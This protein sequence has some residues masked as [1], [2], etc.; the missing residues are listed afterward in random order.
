[1]EESLGGPITQGKKAA[2]HHLCLVKAGVEVYTGG[3][4]TAEGQHTKLRECYDRWARSIMTEDN[5]LG[6]L[7]VPSYVTEKMFL[8]SDA[9]NRKLRA[10]NK[11]ENKKLWRQWIL[12]KSAITNFD[13][14]AVKKA[15][16]R[17]PGK[18]LPSGSDFSLFLERLK[19]ELH[20][21]RSLSARNKAMVIGG[22]A[23]KEADSPNLM[24]DPATENEDAVLGDGTNEEV[25]AGGLGAYTR[26][27]SDDEEDEEM[28]E[29]LAVRGEDD[30]DNVEDDSDEPRAP[31]DYCP[32][33]LLVIMTIGVLST[34]TEAVLGYVDDDPD[35]EGTAL[36]PS[37]I[38]VRND[39]VL[40]A[41]AGVLVSTSASTPVRSAVGRLADRAKYTDAYKE[42]MAQQVE[43]GTRELVLQEKGFSLQEREASAKEREAS[44]KEKEVATRDREVT[45]NS[46]RSIYDDLRRDLRD[47]KDDDEDIEE[48]QRIKDEMKSVKKRR[49]DN[50]YQ[51]DI[52]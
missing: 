24:L 35:G 3:K 27:T 5:T 31:K 21:V 28:E 1:M 26:S 11:E 32:P 12:A 17:M 42:A 22:S 6:V 52:T 16:S 33:R 14:I 20:C 51:V 2:W 49:L 10:H 45:E 15:I 8:T 4:L 40:E 50:S 41:A 48:I 39:A 19:Y 9:N 47:A 18:A 36:V 23:A 44:A 7:S 30:D 13:N 25:A 34:D 38:S 37:R 43:L 46:L 29:D